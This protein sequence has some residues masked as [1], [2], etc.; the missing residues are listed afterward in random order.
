MLLFFVTCLG[1]SPYGIK[2]KNYEEIPSMLNL[3]TNKVQSA[4]EEGYFENGEQAVLEY[5]AEKDPSILKWF[6]EQ[7][8]KLRIGVIN[9]YAVVAVCDDDKPI[10]E[11][12]YCRP[13]KPDK[14]HRLNSDLK[15]CDITMT[16]EEISSICQ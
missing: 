11:D 2:E 4:V 14:D 9:N 10:F 3:L 13:G 8:Y 5:V 12:T 1:C 7:K 15:S 16:A 6:D